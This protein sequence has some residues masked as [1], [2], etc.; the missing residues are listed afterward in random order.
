[1]PLLLTHV[2]KFRL[3]HALDECGKYLKAVPNHEFDET[4]REILGQVL[5][6]KLAVSIIT[7]LAILDGL[8]E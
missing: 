6:Q 4:S 1:M 7:I 5:G 8:I 3:K 2:Q